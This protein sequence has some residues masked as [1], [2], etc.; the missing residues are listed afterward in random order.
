MPL[1][2]T[3]LNEIYRYLNPDEPVSPGDPRYVALACGRGDQDF[4]RAIVRRV[5]SMPVGQYHHH[6]LAGYRGC[7]KSTE[8]HAVKYA[9][10]AQGYLVVYLNAEDA[11]DLADVQ[12]LDVLIALVSAW[13]DLARAI[14]LRVKPSL[15]KDIERWFEE[16]EIVEQRWRESERE[17]EAQAE[18]SARLPLLARLSLNLRTRLRSGSAVREEI[19]RKIERRLSDFEARANA[20][21][22]NIAE[23]A[24]KKGHAGLVAIVDNLEKMPLKVVNSKGQ[25]SHAALFIEHADALKALHCHTVYTVP[26]T[27][28]DDPHL[29]LFYSDPDLMPMVKVRTPDGSP[30]QE[31]VALLR[32]V[33]CRR[34]DVRALFADPNDLEALVLASG[35]VLRDLFQLVLFA[36]DYTG[37]GAQI[38]RQAVQRA[39]A[40]LSREYDGLIHEEDLEV[41]RRA[42]HNAYLPGSARL[43]QLLQKQLVLSYVNGERWLAVHPAVREA[44]RLRAY[45]SAI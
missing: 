31:G 25:T 12:Y 20:L 6:L 38:G 41:L 44:P 27:L 29:K 16:I 10:E 23:L 40:R 22:D 45:L 11:L 42:L 30:D 5:C 3:R 32:E 24:G 4:A 39:I 1:K 36:A 21:L 2:A 13:A 15:V 17:G 8:L 28:I 18:T 9:L 26:T 19:R 33:L 34:M 35:G 14:G 43:S 7:G 37:E